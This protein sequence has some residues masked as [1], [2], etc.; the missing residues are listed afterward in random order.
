MSKTTQP[1]FFVGSGR[2]GTRSIF[3]LF[4][5][6]DNVDVFHEYACTHIQPTA[7][8]YAMGKISR[9]EAA[10]RFKSLHGNA[11]HYSTAE[12]WIDCSNKLSWIIEP[13]VDVF[14]QAKFILITRDGRK[15]SSSYFHK[16]SDEMYDDESVNIL[17]EWLKN[18]DSNPMPPPEKKYWWNIP[19][20]GQP[21]FEE[22]S[23]FD[24]FSRCCYQWRESNRTVLDSLEKI[25]KSS[26]AIFKLETL[27]SNSNE[28]QRLL[29]FMGL[30]YKQSYFEFLKTPQNVIFPMD[31]SL[32]FEQLSTFQK[33]A[34]DL[35]TALGYQDS[36]EYKMSY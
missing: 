10:L 19:Q 20:I 26:Y 4:S 36:A 8:L 32:S 14:P 15:V 17:N 24:Q 3:K 25:N 7:A 18:P 22:F 28:V 27:V 5:G 2:S 16:L 35:Q 1:L 9:E 11:I 30:P 31:F 6:L 13:I 34:G 29:D 23:S 12:F 33:I 21:F